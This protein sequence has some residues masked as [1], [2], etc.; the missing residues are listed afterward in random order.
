MEHLQNALADELAMAAT[1][2][3][4]LAA[5]EARIGCIDWRGRAL[6]LQIEARAD[7]LRERMATMVEALS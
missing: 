3:A 2:R 6:L 1:L 5:R 4:Q 7:E